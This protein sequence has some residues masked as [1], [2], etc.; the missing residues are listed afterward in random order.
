MCSDLKHLVNFVMTYCSFDHFKNNIVCTQPVTTELS[1]TLS[2][3]ASGMA[4]PIA[5]GSDTAVIAG[6]C[7]S[8]YP[9]DHFLF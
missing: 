8:T 1:S 6:A 4:S 7:D 3:S 5:S 2:P 9:P